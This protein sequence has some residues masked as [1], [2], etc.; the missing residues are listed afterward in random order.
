[1]KKRIG[2]RLVSLL[3]T[4]VTILTMLPAMTLLALAA[5]SGSV[6]GLTDEDIGLSFNGD[7]ETPWSAN[8]TTVSGS[9]LSTKGLFITF[10]H[11]STL[12]IKNKK[13]TK[14]TLSFNYA[15]VQ[16]DGTIKVDGD[17][18]TKNGEFSKDL[19]IGGEVNVY[20]KS[21]STATK[22]MIT[23][24]DIKLVSAATATVTFQPAENGSYTVDGK[25]IPPEYTHTQSSTT[26]YQVEAK[27]APGYQ[28][29]DWYDV[30]NNKSISRLPKAELNIEK[31]CTIKARFTTSGL[32]LFETGGLVYDDLTNAITA[33]SG[34]PSALITQVGD[35]TV[36]GIY[37]IPSGVTLLIP[38][39][40]AGTL[41]TETPQAIRT[42][43]QAK[44]YK[45]L[46]MAAGSS[47]TLARGAAISVGGQYYAASGNQKGQIVGYHGYIKMESGSAITVQGG[48]SLYAWGFISGSG[49]VTVQSGGSVYEWYQILDFRGGS[50]SSNM[51]NKVFPFNQYAVQNIEAP[52]TLYTGA[53][54][55]AY[56]TVFANSKIN[57]TPV[58]FIGINGLFKLNSGSLTKAYDGSTDRIIY[59]IDGT[60]EL[61]SLSISL[62]PIATDSKNFVL[63]LNN[64]MTVNLTSGSKL[65]VNQ[66]VALL[67]GVEVSIA[68]GAE[69][70]VSSGKSMF[71]YDV[72]EWG[73]YCGGGNNN[74]TFI[75]VVYAPGRT[76]TRARLAD[77]KIDVNGLL[78]VTK[79]REYDALA[80]AYYNH[81]IYTTESGANICSSEGTG[82]YIQLGNCEKS[83]K[84][85]YQYDGSTTAHEIPITP[86][87]L[88]NAAGDP[89]PT[90]GSVANDTFTYCT[91]PHCGGGKWVKNLQAA[92][93]IDSNGTPTE[94]PTLQAAVNK[95][96]QNSSG[97]TYI[98]L[99]HDTTEKPISVNNKSLYLD[100]NGCTVKGDISVTD[101]HKLYG[102]DSS[103]K[104]DYTTAP[105]GKIVGTVKGCAPTYQTPGDTN[106]RYVAILSEENGTSTL[107]F[108][109]FNI[110][111]T[112]YRFELTT[113]D[114]PK[115]ALFFIGKFQGDKA[116]KD[117]LTSL[118]FTL[119]DKK[120]KQLGKANYEFTAGT[121]FPDMPAE[122]KEST[123]EVVRSGD[124]YL[125]E[126]YLMRSFDKENHN[127]YTEEIGATAQATFDNGGK[128]DSETQWLSFEDAW[129]NAE[130]SDSAQQEIL[131]NFLQKLGITKQTE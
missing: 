107:S 58:Q 103:A 72:D 105:T 121:V 98:K 130:I 2:R 33:A 41:Y 51:G 129:K 113:G 120:D 54:E 91:C 40:E 18:K 89:T 62:G 81:D 125:F 31:D 1:M 114:T 13:G 85:T 80:I 69:L 127:G 60:A 88:Q 118:G 117:Y 37:T 45:T 123:S 15:I 43:P 47:I 67:P 122:E 111:V 94:Y 128:Q 66:S 29:M 101:N 12:T 50:A 24:T 95:F 79:K 74:S 8:G 71:I 115:C 55:I 42:A 63:P 77:A 108:H 104:A 52:L 49:S 92:A 97:T 59:T 21:G 119:K 96:S 57:S 116:A 14:A 3:L 76:G 56:T 87:K 26:A 82:K 27:P 32:A 4:V 10:S 53:T 70:T 39:D 30:S 11:D 5:E 25:A 6:G 99:L 7:V 61:N 48:A 112:G 126:A 65:T 19:E 17:P 20:I 106:D 23:I 16:G 28:F 9:V 90:A 86:A 93:I 68:K 38:F 35:G 36:S 100:L 83:D 131:D 44:P 22:T 102:M 46:T 34:K 110:S 109:R 75:P 84:F 78:Q 64:N 73:S 124:A